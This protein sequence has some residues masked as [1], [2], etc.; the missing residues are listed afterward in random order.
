MKRY[1]LVALLSL[2]AA[3]YISNSIQT[4]RAGTLLAI[5]DALGFGANATGG[6]GGT[7]QVVTNL[8][9]AGAGSFRQAVSQANSIVVFDVGGVINLQSE[10]AIASNVTIFG[11]TAPGQGIAIQGGTNGYNLSLSNSTNDI[12]QYLRVLQGGPGTVQ[13]TAVDMYGTTNA[14]LD[15]VS[16]EYGPYDNID[17]VG[18][19][20]TGGDITIQN[21]IVADPIAAQTFNIHD[22]TGP[23]SFFNNLLVSA[24]NRNPMAKAD[25]QFVNNVIYNFEAGYTVA[26][27][28]GHF[29]QDIV[30]NYFITGP[31]TTNPGD[32]FFQMDSNINAYA[33]GN[34]ENSSRNGVLNGSSVYPTGVTS[35]ST[36]FY[37]ENAKT[38]LQAFSNDVANAG[39]SLHLNSV[40]AQV[41]ANVQSLGT[42]GRILNSPADTGISNAGFGT[43]QGGS[44]PLGG[45][46]GSVPIAWIQQHGL[47]SADF[48]NPAG[49]YN[50]T[51]YNNIEK[52]AAAIAGEQIQLGFSVYWSGADADNTWNTKGNWSTSP[53]SQ[54]AYNNTPQSL[55]DVYFAS[56]ATVT[57]GA[58]QTVNSV[59][60]TSAAAV[61]IGA[62]IH[63]LTVGSGGINATGTGGIVF[64]SALILNGDI[65]ASGSNITIGNGLTLNNGCDEW[66]TGSGHTLT[67]N[68]PLIRNNATIDFAT[69]G[70]VNGNSLTNNANTGIIGGWATF[71]QT[72]WATVSNNNVV[73]YAEYL[74]FAGG[75]TVISQMSGYHSSSNF[76][77]TAA[78][79]GNVAVANGTTD[80]NTLLDTDTTTVRLLA[81]GTGQTLRL[82]AA[83]GVMQAANGLGLVIG[84][85]GTAGTLTSGGPTD[86]NP[87]ELVLLNYS[88][89][90]ALTINANIT[91]NGTGV[92]T[93]TAAG[94]GTI[95]LNGTNSYSGATNVNAGTLFLGIASALPAA[96]ELNISSSATL[97]IGGN[98][99]TIGSLNGTGAVDNNSPANTGNYTLTLGGNNSDSTFN[100]VIQDSVG[101]LSVI[102]NGSGTLTLGGANTFS[103]GLTLNAG[104]LNLNNVSGAG[105]GTITLNGGTMNDSG[106]ILN[107]LYLPTGKT[108]N[109]V[110]ENNNYAVLGGNTAD[111]GTL[112]G[113]GVLDISAFY[114]RNLIGGDWS[115]FTGTVN[116]MASRNG[117]NVGFD[118]VSNAT[119]VIGFYLNNG[120]LDLNGTAT[121]SITFSYFNGQ[122]DHAPYGYNVVLGA[123]TG[124]TES[125][126]AGT[127]TAPGATLDHALNYVV[128][129]LNTSTTFNGSLNGTSGYITNFYKIGT[130]ALTLSGPESFGG[131][132]EINGGTLVIDGSVTNAMS[133][134]VDAAGIVV[135]TDES[136]T[137]FAA[138]TGGELA[139]TGIITANV[140]N[141]GVSSSGDPAAGPAGE[142]HIT[143]NLD[144]AGTL[145]ANLGSKGTSNLLVISGNLAL[146]NTS[147][148]NLTGL[149]GSYDGSSYTIATFTGTLT[150]RF[151]SVSGLAAD[152]QLEYSPHSIMLTPTP[153]PGELAITFLGLGAMAL[154]RR[155][156]FCNKR[157]S[158]PC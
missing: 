29:N 118:G 115:A 62:G 36:P 156:R 24:H 114:V 80:I 15:H 75:N 25:A 73:P 35:A 16:I 132:L 53:N 72:D 91:D 157:A 64:D 100:G 147:K 43:L 65:H 93:L 66:T 71:N 137:T 85:S 22:Q 103:G 8:N 158:G 101:T 14:L 49:D 108:G 18:N 81:V 113:G 41:L 40:D 122:T 143:G 82:G 109:I 20:S 60:S 28:S 136:N 138:G 112:S 5:P 87:G 89:A 152:Y 2:A 39:D 106:E 123:L 30:G 34:L 131:R 116:L 69:S 134:T 121:D 102:K 26:D 31:S 6:R 19:G 74:D 128:G 139:G 84:T 146:N 155:S 125:T 47:T 96:T 1:H 77:I 144:N 117:T 10:L 94:A 4:I 104:T 21:S 105:V 52:Y 32:A 149:A 150:G 12:V 120:T 63:T 97:D 95:I 9:D 154:R 67:I 133:I 145:M 48:A 88:T 153:E 90:A 83:G 58:N 129:G 140:T 11:Q 151:N 148:L 51:G 45:Q 92:A 68:G 79:T 111:S 50:N 70:T 55:D 3:G 13:K 130:G 27:T 44:L 38:A 110:F 54:V 126:L 37:A 57:L 98:N 141:Y 33:S 124:T 59:N 23:T 107:N 61:T 142:L 42:S 99:V 135:S 119:G 78:S 17:A 56:G 46:S 86:G 127:Q 7:V 76:R